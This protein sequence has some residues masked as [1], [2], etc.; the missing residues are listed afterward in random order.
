MVDTCMTL[1]EKHLRI[2]RMWKNK[3]FIYQCKKCQKVFQSQLSW[4][5]AYCVGCSSDNLKFYIK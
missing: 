2:K 4:L 5:E 1:K 3:R